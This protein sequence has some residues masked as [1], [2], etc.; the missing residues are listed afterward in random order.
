MGIPESVL[1]WKP[2][3]PSRNTSIF[4]AVTGTLFSLYYYDRRECKRIRQ[5]YIDQVR[6][7]AEE[8]LA[9]YE[10][11]RI[12]QVYTAKC[13]G[14][15]DPVKAR[16]WFNKYVKPILVAA[17]VDVETLSGLTYG[18]L[19][20]DLRQRIYARRRQLAGLEPW[21]IA[22]SSSGSVPPSPNSTEVM[23]AQ[24]ALAAPFALQPQQQLQRE[25]EGATV[26]VGRP[27]YKEYMVALRNGWTT[28]L[29]PQRE[30]LD[31]AL[32][33]QLA[34]DDTFAE[35]PEE[36]A[37][38]GAAAATTTAST[39]SGNAAAAPASVDDGLDDIER[40]NRALAESVDDD[41]GAPLPNSSIGG[42]SPNPFGAPS[43]S[44]VSR[45]PS[46]SSSPAAAPNVD[47][48]ILAPPA[49]IPAQPP[50][51]Y[52]DYVNLTGWR[53]IPRRMVNFFN[54]RKD[55]RQGAE[56][57]LAI[58]TNNKSTA[59]EFSAPPALETSRAAVDPPQDGDLD[60]GL[61]GE[62][63]FQPPHFA[64]VHSSLIKAREAFYAELPRRLRDTRTLVRGQ[65][66]PTK[67]E[68]NDP[69]KSEAQLKV[70]RL[71]REREWRNTEEGWEM[72]RK[73]AGVVWAEA[74]RG[75]LRV[76]EGRREA[77]KEE[78]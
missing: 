29:P 4:F 15:D 77:R 69:P 78:Q 2:R 63:R 33:K 55:V 1:R 25:L 52:I 34:G 70:E 56:A 64:K 32:S 28:P 30:D 37:E 3:P 21:G 67:V 42:K 7:Y 49:Q 54:R 61:E 35:L 27:A 51:A 39:D 10:Y 57:A 75:S 68:K 26:L 66:E 14:D 44:V 59:R 60:W 58:I 18:G 9:P 20:R 48:R 62:T 71:E 72:L 11:P 16:K 38:A 53:L 76:L 13:P 65:R 41:A 73:E 43:G 23:A 40:R 45:S 8:P 24:A 31:E 22:P 46:S 74:F 5:S 17:A 19:A 50:L 36:K 6:P 12:V 47:P